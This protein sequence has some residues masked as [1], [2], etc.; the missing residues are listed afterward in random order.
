MKSVFWFF[1]IISFIISDFNVSI[2]IVNFVFH[3]F[4]KFWCVWF[5]R[6]FCFRDDFDIEN[7]FV[8]FLRII[9]IS[10]ILCKEWKMSIVLIEIM[11]CIFFREILI[12][13]FIDSKTF[14]LRKKKSINWS[15]FKSNITIVIK[16]FQKS[17]NWS[18]F[19]KLKNMLTKM[20]IQIISN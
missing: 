4:I 2:S 8:S 1:S 18:D 14:E 3:F 15:Q 19:R 16:L 13:W 17:L 10:L 11:T 6:N 12:I 7:T 9:L 20:S 5:F